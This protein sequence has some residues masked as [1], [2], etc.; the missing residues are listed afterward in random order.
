MKDLLEKLAKGESTVDEVLTAIEDS[1]KDL[2]PRSRLNDKNDEI[3]GLKE[4]ISQRDKQIGE[5][6][7]LSKGN[8]ALE[9]QLEDLKKA[10]DDWQGRFKETQLNNA[11]KLAVAKDAI[12]ANDILHFI[13]KEGMELLEDGTVKGLEDAVKMLRE[14]KSYLFSEEG[15]RGRKPNDNPNPPS[16]VKNPFSKEHFNLTEQGRLYREDP[17]LYKTLKAQA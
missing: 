13:N 15:L 14:S 12:D 16:T 7:Q 2:I 1:K 11:I 5:L 3:K 8:E 17:E 6:Q 9:K 4:E 10:N